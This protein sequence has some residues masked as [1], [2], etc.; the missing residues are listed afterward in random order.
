MARAKAA[1]DSGALSRF[2]ETRAIEWLLRSG[3]GASSPGS[4]LGGL[5][6]Q[7]ALEQMPIAAAR[8]TVASLDPLVASTRWR[9]QR[10]DG[11]VIEEV[12]LHGMTTLAAASDDKAALW[13]TLSDTKHQIEW[14][15]N[16]LGGFTREQQTYLETICL[17]MA[18]PLQFVVQ[19]GVTRTLLE[20]YLGR[21]SAEKVLSGTVRRGVG[22]V[23]EA[24]VWISDLRDFS[25]LSEALP[26]YQVITALNDYCARLVGAIHP[27][28][29]EVLKFIGD[30]LLAIFPLAKCG[31]NAACDA[32]VAA[33]RAARQGIARLDY[34]RVAANL[35]PLP[36]G[37]GLHLGAVVYG[38]IGASDRLDFTAIG[39]AV[40]V[41]SRI[42]GLCRSLVCPVLISQ[43][44][45]TRCT[46]SLT[47]VGRHV[48]RG[49][50]QPLELF[51]LSE[52]APT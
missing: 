23:I 45:A 34:E 37:I 51:T 41:A 27:Y 12:M 31:E 32:A 11:R 22:E 33:V 30:G 21:R 50:A 8:L 1:R 28:G 3:V 47:P 25:M 49:V 24:V 5:C 52:L 2:P 10:E 9:W 17:T 38:N 14:F 36:F 18:A 39:S 13:F 46:A 6:N 35:P 4:L 26:P 29:G 16:S 48:L 19:C 20:A 40:N 44:V 42:E 43:A 7:L 15:A